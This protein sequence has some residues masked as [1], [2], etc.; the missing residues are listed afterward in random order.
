MSRFERVGL[1]YAPITRPEELFDDPH[2][3]A[4]GGLAPI[5]VPA[6]GSGAGRVIETR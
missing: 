5:T 4:T 3:L 6:D 1:P 2:L